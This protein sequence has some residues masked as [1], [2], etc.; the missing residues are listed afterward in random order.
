VCQTDIC[1]QLSNPIDS[2]FT[3]CVSIAFF[4]FRCAVP[5]HFCVSSPPHFPRSR[6][7]H[8]LCVDYTSN[9]TSRPFDVSSLVVHLFRLRWYLPLPPEVNSSFR[10]R[11]LFV[12]RFSSLRLL[13]VNRTFQLCGTDTFSLFIPRRFQISPRPI[14]PLFNQVYFRFRSL[15]QAKQRLL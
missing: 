1:P 15:V 12:R 9:A 11:L 3:F 5:R 7:C 2:F 6:P 13:C 14:S 8:L 10:Q 4:N